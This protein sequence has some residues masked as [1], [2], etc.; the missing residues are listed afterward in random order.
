M[1]G[2]NGD[3]NCSETFQFCPHLEETNQ[4]F[5]LTLKAQC[6]ISRNYVT[7]SL[8][9]GSKNKKTGREDFLSNWNPAG[10]FSLSIT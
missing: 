8:V 9:P 5:L 10:Y 1:S 3:V 6:E 2:K 4:L 7:G